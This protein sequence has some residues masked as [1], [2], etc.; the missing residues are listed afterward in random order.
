MIALI[1]RVREASVTIDGEE[2]ARIGSGL[3]ILL[4]V[5]VDDSESNAAWLARKCSALRVFRDDKGALNRSLLDIG[6]DALVVSQFTLYGNVAGGNRPSFVDAARPEH[7][8]P[9]YQLFTRQ[10]SEHLGKP[11]ATGRFGA[12]MDVALVNDGPVTVWI[13]REPRPHAGV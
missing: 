4:G 1:Q 12:M 11:V 2:I 5:H 9:M 13:E 10:L 6:G 8:E 3:L 7:A